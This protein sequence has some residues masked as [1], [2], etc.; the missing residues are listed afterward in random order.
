MVKQTIQIYA[1]VKPLAR[2]QQA[3]IYSVEEDEKSASSLEIIVPR[4][5]ADGFVNNKRESY[6]FK[7][8]KIFDQEA[9][10][11]AVFESIAKPVAECALA[12][13]N[14]TIFAY[15]QTGSGKTFTITG[16]A[17]RYS[18]RGIIP[19]TLSY[20]FQQLEKDSS[21]VYTTHVSYLEIYNECGY[22]LL[23]PRHEASRLED[24]PKV[25]IMEDPDQNI[26]LKNLSLQQATNEG[27]AL[28]LLFL[29][30]TNRM[31]AETPMNQ[32]STR[33][34]CIFTIHISSKEPGS[35]TVR[36]SK[37]HLVDLAGSERVA[38]TGVGGQLLT[39]AKYINLSLHYLEQ[40]IIA[41]AEKN[42]SHIPYRNSM[43]TSV[44]RDSLGGNCMT[45]MIATLSLDKRNIDE[46][47]ST[48]RFAQRVALIKNEAVLN[49]EIDSRL[50]I[51]QLKKVIQ[52]L[53]DELAMVTGEQRTEELTPEELLQLDELIKRFLEDPD[54]E[55]MLDIGADMRKIKHCFSYIKQLINHTN[56]PDRSLLSPDIAGDNDTNT[57]EK[58]EELKK[59]RDLLHQR[60][61]EINILVS[62]L[63]KEKKKA[64]DAL[65]Q[66]SAGSS[67]LAVSESSL[68]ISLE[69]GRRPSACINVKDTQDFSSSVY[70]SAF[71]PRQTGL[72][73]K[74][75]LGRQE[76]FEIFKRDYVDTVTI[77]DNKQLLKQR[78]AEAKS[79]GEKINEVRNKINHLKG[80]RTQRHMQRAA[81]GVA[82]PSEE[83]HESD[84]VEETLRAQIEE[85]K[86]SY[87][88]MFNRLK[89]L[90]IEIEH[91]QLLMEKAKVK[92]Q[93]DFEVWWSEEALNLQDQQKKLPVSNSASAL[94]ASPQSLESQQH[95][96]T[97][98]FSGTNTSGVNPS[99]DPGRKNNLSR[100][101]N[102]ASAARKKGEGNREHRINLLTQLS[103]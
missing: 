16:G 99:E 24:L 13:Y 57:P 93:K 25:T 62:M 101:S 90:K 31:I 61:N 103:P 53:K 48:C 29:G 84:P 11:D 46:S 36:R 67:G 86:K 40:V 6:K 77:E 88:T 42:R 89:V 22:D 100:L 83:L 73:E 102:S 1:R 18:D 68:S 78:F 64:Q 37:L 26:H 20:I 27:D 92:L 51:I 17:E 71:L 14:G 7:F 74:M 28:N 72:G 54:P 23:D 38:K 94:R 76:A 34:H 32:A 9:K 12:G 5:L 55:S 87:K 66:L 19:R 75:S 44:L 15:G 59:L 60:D 82:S 69:E 43:M 30:D 79:L 50:M 56:I 65:F 4:D 80:E 98:S 70:R 85:E 39:E 10:Q 49:E 35:A 3:G 95:L 96:Y 58:K 33:S 41:L 21:K 2:R 52:E 97:N 63:K 8:Q 81:L 45:T 47:I 91:L